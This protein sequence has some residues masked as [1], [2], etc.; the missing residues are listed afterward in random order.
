MVRY[1]RRGV[2]VLYRRAAFWADAGGVLIE[3]VIASFAMW[4]VVAVG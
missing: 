2:G 1:R 3:I 4:V